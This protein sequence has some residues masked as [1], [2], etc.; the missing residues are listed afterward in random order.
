MEIYHIKYYLPLKQPKPVLNINYLLMM[1]YIR[2]E[3]VNTN[4]DIFCIILGIHIIPWMITK[5]PCDHQ[6]Q[7]W[8]GVKIDILKNLLEDK[9]RES[10]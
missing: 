5:C 7:V 10:F 1:M 4:F 9:Y 6:Q 2:R 3:P 8:T